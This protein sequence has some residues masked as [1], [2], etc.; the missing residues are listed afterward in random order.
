MSGTVGCQIAGYSL[1]HSRQA[2]QVVA[3]E[4]RVI[5]GTENA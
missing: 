4:I 3:L 1:E 5:D 2:D